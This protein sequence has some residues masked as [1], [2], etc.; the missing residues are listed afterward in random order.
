MVSLAPS[1]TTGALV[2]TQT[3]NHMARP[4]ANHH[5]ALARDLGTSVYALVSR[6][7]R[8]LIHNI[9]IDSRPQDLRNHGESPHAPVH[10]Y[11][12]MA[13]DVEQFIQEHRLTQATLIGHSMFVARS[14]CQHSGPYDLLGA[15]R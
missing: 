14:S 9:E 12:A 5:R 11:S 4:N 10:D 8:S 13:D 6:P 15:Q 1:R 2:S 3:L 7:L